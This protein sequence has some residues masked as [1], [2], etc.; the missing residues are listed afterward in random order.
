MTPRDALYYSVPGWVSDPLIEDATRFAAARPRIGVGSLMRRFKI[1][2]VR[3]KYLF[4]ALAE[5]RLFLSYLR[6]GQVARVNPHAWSAL[7]SFL[8]ADNYVKPQRRCVRGV[9]IRV[10]NIA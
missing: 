10:K 1:G 6:A 3:A 2:P 4:V 9:D 8:N 5:R 7:Y